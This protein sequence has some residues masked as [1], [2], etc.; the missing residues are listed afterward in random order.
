MKYV[1]VKQVTKNVKEGNVKVVYF[2]DDAEPYVVEKLLKLCTDKNIK[3]IH[4]KTMKELGAMSNIDVGTSC[5]A[6]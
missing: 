1:G 3:I 6:E 5:S 4:V 2:A